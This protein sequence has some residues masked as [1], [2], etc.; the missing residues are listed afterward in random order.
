MAKHRECPELEAFLRRMMRALVRR[1]AEGDLEAVEVL[2]RL[3]GEIAQATRDAGDAA[4]RC[5]YSYTQ[6][7]DALGITRQAARQRFLTRE[8]DGGADG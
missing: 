6:I 1:A 3:N 4:W 5:G 8:R 7:G 2:A